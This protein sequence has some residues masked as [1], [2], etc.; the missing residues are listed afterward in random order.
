MEQI[1]RCP[2]CGSNN[3]VIDEHKLKR[4]DNLVYLIHCK[5]CG[6]A[7]TRDTK[8]QAVNDWNDR[9]RGD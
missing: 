6:A 9:A 1:C 3:V 2:L 5:G 4:S 8:E 7:L